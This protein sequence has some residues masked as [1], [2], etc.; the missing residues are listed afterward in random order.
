M[1]NLGF[2][3][4]APASFA[5]KKYAQSCDTKT[6]NADLFRDV[7]RL[8][9]N[10]A[11]YALRQL[12]K[13]PYVDPN[14]IVIM[15]LSQ[16][17]VTTAT[18]RPQPGE[19]ARII[20]GWTCHAGWQEYKGLKAKASTPVLSLIGELDPWYKT[21]WVKGDCG[22]YMRKNNASRSVVYRSGRLM[23]EHELLDHGQP[24]KEV[25]Q[26]LNSLGLIE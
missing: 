1:S 2:V 16:G 19:A 12:R 22:R 6:N 21:K 25:V 23:K 5:R 17:A 24:R 8:R 7:I 15:G 13:L 11:A 10:D 4:A 26:F 18:L 14:K 3:V 9:Q 20:E